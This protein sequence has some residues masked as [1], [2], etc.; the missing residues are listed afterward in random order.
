MDGCTDV[1]MDKLWMNRCV[2]ERVHVCMYVCMH[3]CM[4]VC[5]YVYLHGYMC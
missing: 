5:L 4:H 2:A 3:A 1:C